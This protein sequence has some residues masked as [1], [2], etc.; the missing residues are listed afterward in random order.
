[1][2]VAILVPRRNDNGWRDRLWAHCRP[3]WE[4]NFPNW[5]IFEGH[6]DASEGP[7]N[8]SAAVNRAASLADGW[9]NGWDVA[10][11][12]DSDT[13]SEPEAVR[14]AVQRT[15]ETGVLSVAHDERHMLSRRGTDQVLAGTAP[16]DLQGRYAVKRTYR[17]SVSC[18]IAVRRQEWDAVGGFDTRFEGWGFEDTAFRVAIETVTDRAMHVE[19]ASCYHLW[20]ETAPGADHSSPT[21]AKNYTLKVRYE[22]A[23]FQPERLKALLT[24]APDPG[25]AYS[26]IPRIM[27]R[28]V[29]ADTPAQVE[30]W[31][32]GLQRLHPDW[33]LKTWRDPLSAEDFPIT[34]HLHK[35]C[36]SGAQ[37]AGLVRLELLVTHGGVYVDSDVEGI[38]PLDSLLHVPA[39]AAWEDE[40]VVPDAILGAMPGHPVF[41]QMLGRAMSLVELGS[42]DAW[43]T[44]PGVTTAML[45]WREDVLLLPPG[46][47]YPVHYREK[48]NV[49]TRNKQ[50]WV[51]LEHKWHHSWDAKKK[52]KPNPTRQVESRPLRQRPT[53]RAAPRQKSVPDEPKVELLT[54][55]PDGVTMAICMPWRDSG[56]KW[57]RLAFEWC[58]KLWS[59]AGF[60]VYEGD[61]KSR[62]AMC[63]NAAVKAVADEVDVLVFADADTWA[64]PEQVITA[65]ALA[66]EKQNAVHAFTKY[67][68]LDA[69]RTRMYLKK[70]PLEV[71]AHSLTR[72][73]KSKTEHVSGLTAV[74]VGLWK[75]IGGFDERFVGWGF[76]D[77]AFHLAAEVM[78]GEVLRIPGPAIHWYHGNDPS[79]AGQVSPTDPR[80]ELMQEYCQAAGR[81]PSSGR[82]GRLVTTGFISVTATEPD[83]KKMQSVLAGSGGPFSRPDAVS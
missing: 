77:Q 71:K 7:F 2:K 21:F 1:M 37:K 23:H 33:E 19:K 48:H 56:D 14:A 80:L 15:W 50:P 25:L 5:P 82:V 53:P 22:R 39:F 27:H 67:I 17:D 57:R 26:T 51:F 29:P 16:K 42:Q 38:R 58:N 83:A 43:E 30:D 45:P 36:A 66:H 41:K 10:L 54:E 81:A 78:G 62:S 74:P 12:I 35:L 24:G 79:K 72:M 60:T 3:I 44:G 40:K 52:K 32:L 63:N 46:S 65:A 4:Q 47:F 69:Q 76:E 8:R 11:V 64:K 6:H 61:G 70:D 34:H 55:M 20:H 59:D 73:G 68:K 18:A 9:M 49:G 13:I 31:W 28:T 75:Q